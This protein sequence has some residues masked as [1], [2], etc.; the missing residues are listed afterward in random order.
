MTGE[1]RTTPRPWHTLPAPGFKTGRVIGPAGTT[2]ADVRYRNGDADAAL[3]VTAV[4]QYDRLRAIEEAAR[5]LVD[6]PVIVD[7][8]GQPV[9]P[10]WSAMK[11]LHAALEGAPH[12]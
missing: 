5:A 11:A 7:A 10:Y 8:S 6:V 1:A 2:V 9:E 4:N 3:I 12:E